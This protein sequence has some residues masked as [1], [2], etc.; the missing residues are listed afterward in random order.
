MVQ[1]AL[2]GLGVALVPLSLVADDLAAGNLVLAVDGPDVS[3]A[4]YAYVVTPGGHGRPLLHEF[5]SWL[6][7]EGT[8]SNQFACSVI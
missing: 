5:C 4:D 2:E 6:S 1:A 7:E 8:A 3:A